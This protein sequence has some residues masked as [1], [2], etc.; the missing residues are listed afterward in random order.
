MGGRQH[1][2]R[3]KNNARLWTRRDH[4]DCLYGAADRSAGKPTPDSKTARK[5]RKSS[6]RCIS[7]AQTC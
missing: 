5:L 2:G 6:S 4:E 3:L 7:D 1:P